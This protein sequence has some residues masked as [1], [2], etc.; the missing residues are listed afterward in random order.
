[1]IDIFKFIVRSI[2]LREH[3]TVNKHVNYCSFGQDNLFVRIFHIP[4]KTLQNLVPCD[5]GPKRFFCTITTTIAVRGLCCVYV[6]TCT[7][8][9]LL[10]ED[11]RYIQTYINISFNTRG[12]VIKCVRSVKNT[13]YVAVLRIREIESESECKRIPLAACF[14]F[15]RVSEK[16]AAFGRSLTATLYAHRIF[17]S[18]TVV[19]C[20]REKS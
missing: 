13:N 12:H 4:Y 9:Q 8:I 1:M 20:K 17:C 6:C 15:W 7:T 2:V 19:R 3:G 11:M 10:T 18:A 14:G 16:I 5:S